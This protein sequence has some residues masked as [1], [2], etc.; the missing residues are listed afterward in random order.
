MVNMETKV[1]RASG[2]KGKEVR[3][4][5]KGGFLKRGYYYKQ[6]GW[7]LGCVLVGPYKTKRQ[8]IDALTREIVEAA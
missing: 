5:G 4:D 8:A 1:I 2:S 7:A 6:P 3:A